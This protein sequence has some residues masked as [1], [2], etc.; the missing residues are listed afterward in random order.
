VTEAIDRS[1]PT[2][3]QV[4]ACAALA[5]DKK[6]TEPVI[7]AV[8][9]LTSFADFFLIASAPSERQV[10]AIGAHIEDTMRNAGLRPLSVEGKSS[11]AWVLLDFGD[12]VVHLFH[13][14]AREYYDLEGFWADA[15]RVEINEAEGLAWAKQ[16]EKKSA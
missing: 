14:A 3:Q 11:G 9:K 13:D 2:F 16:A 7:L 15:P 10:A 4:Q 1:D 12:F 5:L 8:S 6:A